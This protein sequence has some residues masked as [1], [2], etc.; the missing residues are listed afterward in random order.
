MP[1]GLTALL[2]SEPRDRIAKLPISS[3]FLSKQTRHL[4]RLLE[5]PSARG[6]VLAGRAGDPPKR[7][8]ADL[9]HLRRN[10]G[11]EIGIT[12]VVNA[13]AE[14]SALERITDSSQTQRRVGKV[15]ELEV[16]V[17]SPRRQAAPQAV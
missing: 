11:P 10:T 7:A 5:L 1:S 16:V 15:P 2:P 6:S 4:C 14:W 3:N 8:V 13:P 12:A 17:R 9:V